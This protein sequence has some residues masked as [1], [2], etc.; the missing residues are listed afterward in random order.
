MSHAVAEE[1]ISK[2][3]SILME[4]REAEKRSDE[5]VQSAR[6]K[7][8]LIIQE[9]RSNA[10]KLASSGESEIRRSYEK[11]LVDFRDKS[12]LLTEEKISEGKISARQLKSKAEKN[13]NKAAD[14]ILKKFEEGL[15]A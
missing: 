15:N 7:R 11:K 9:A 6:I 3:A 10:A 8:D 14:F 4:I 5:I 12:R 2:E 13:I 1:A